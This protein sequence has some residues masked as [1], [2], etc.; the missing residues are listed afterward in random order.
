VS[1]VSEPNQA[2]VEINGAYIGETP[3]EHAV[4]RNLDLVIKLS[5][6]GYETVFLK[7]K[8]VPS[9]LGIA[10]IIGGSILLLPFLGFISP[11]A[12]KYEPSSFG[13]TLPPVQKE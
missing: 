3:I 11:A 5:K 1:I 12:W 2:R 7:A 4:R 10:D 8:S 6:E 9:T 13:T